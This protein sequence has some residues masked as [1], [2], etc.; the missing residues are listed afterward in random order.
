M[1]FHPPTNKLVIY[2]GVTATPAVALSDTWTYNGQWA[3]QTTV[4]APARWGHRM[5]LN[6]ANNTIV[7]F[8]G[9]SP[10]ISGLA[11]DTMVYNGTSWTAVTTAN[12]PSPR[13]LYGMCYDR[14]RGVMVL[15]GG[16][17]ALGQRNDT[18]E[19]DGTNWTLRTTAHAPVPREEMVMEFD[20][21]LNRVVLFGGCNETLGAVY[22]DTW[23]YDGSDWLDVTP[24]TSPAPRFR[25]ASAFDTVRNRLVMYG[26][27]DNAQVFAETFEFTGDEWTQIP[28]GNMP[29]NMTE[30]YTGYD[31]TRKKLVVFGGFGTTF[32]N[33]TWEFTGATGGV[34]GTYGTGCDTVQ[35]EPGI[36]GSVPTLNQTFTL[37]FD[38][39]PPTAAAMLVA[40]GLSN[41]TWNGLPLPID[42]GIIGLPG[43]NLIAAADFLDVGLA[44]GGTATYGLMI[45][46][47][48]SLLNASLYMQGIV[49]DVS[50]PT[51]FSGATRGGR[52]IIGN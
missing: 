47:Q 15:F 27:Y 51:L 31:A 20:P 32:L 52:A 49:L 35:G 26:G 44:A 25:T 11:N 28:T 33:E 13:F 14:L 48:M 23:F 50:V 24:A 40:I 46:N 37:T 10:T 41:L 34:F 30:A 42:L 19:F 6:S 38:N 2:G 18:W 29:P 39:L 45:P 9:R 1:A 8:G 3:Q 5:V 43:C 12:A 36:A 22:G 16:R 7:T 21:T 4:A 17:S